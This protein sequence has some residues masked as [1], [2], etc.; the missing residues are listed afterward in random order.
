MQLKLKSSI[1]FL[2]SLNIFEYQVTRGWGK[3]QISLNQISA[4]AGTSQSFSHPLLLT[5]VLLVLRLWV[6]SN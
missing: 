3:L 1:Q 5:E 2:F 6:H 4:F